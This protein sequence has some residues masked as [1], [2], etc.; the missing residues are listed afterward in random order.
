MGKLL[1]QNDTELYLGLVHDSDTLDENRARIE[2]ASN[3]VKNFGIA[4]ECGF[5]RK[6][7]QAI[8]GLLRLHVMLATSKK[9][10]I[11]V[12]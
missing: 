9:H 11:S 12:Y 4:T 2:K 8:P 6:N 10:V 3:Y 7:P 1:L 5:G